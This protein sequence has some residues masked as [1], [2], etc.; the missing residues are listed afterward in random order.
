MTARTLFLAGLAASG[1]IIAT[2]GITLWLAQPPDR[3]A[4]TQGELAATFRQLRGDVAGLE[5]QLTRPDSRMVE[6][7]SPD[8]PAVLT[9][10]PNDDATLEELAAQTQRLRREML[11]IVQNEARRRAGPEPEILGE[12]EIFAGSGEVFSL[13][14]PPGTRAERTTIENAGAST[15]RSPRL[16]LK[17]RPSPDSVEAILEA[18]LAGAKTDEEKAVAL[19]SFVEQARV[20]DWPAHREKSDP[21]KLASVYGYGFCNHAARS[22]AVLAQAAG[23]EAR[24]R[25][26]PGEHVVCEILIDGRWALFDP[27]GGIFYRN[28]SGQIATV[29]EL[30]A[31][32]EWIKAQPSPLYPEEKLVRLYQRDDAKLRSDFSKDSGFRVTFDL[33]PGESI[34]FLR[35]P[36]GHFFAS[37]YL[38][39]PLEYANGVWRFSPDWRHGII[40]AATAK[41][42]RAAGNA[43]EKI[44][45]AQPAELIYE[46]SPGHPILDGSIQTDSPV[47]VSRDGLTWTPVTPGEPLGKYLANAG[48]DPDYRLFVRLVPSASRI[49]RFSTSLVFQTARRAL[50]LPDGSAA[51]GRLEFSADGPVVARVVFAVATTPQP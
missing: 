11:V 8:G 35:R 20:H 40:G 47:S 3:D 51:I 4:L 38:E 48:G 27:D 43:L 23:L 49:A 28:A 45:P 44:D 41:N 15:I 46:F 29:D 17:D 33:R 9:G 24:T 42:L 50:P 12:V 21:V 22:L 14:F 5:R 26:Y 36:A 37:R 1:L 13:P 25:D 7:P 31:H 39:I 34:T 2:A 16:I 32:P 19:W 18:Q 30:R 10:E 6:E